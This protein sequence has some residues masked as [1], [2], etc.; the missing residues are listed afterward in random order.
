MGITGGVQWVR[1][2]NPNVRSRFIYDFLMFSGSAMWA[3]TMLS[4]YLLQ[5]TSSAKYVGFAEGTQGLCMA[6]I[7]IP[8]GVLADRLGRGQIL[9]AASFVGILATAAVSAALWCKGSEHAVYTMFVG[10]LGLCGL[11]NGLASPALD[12]NFADSIATGDR[13]VLYTAKQMCVYWASAAGPLV[14]VVLF[15]TL[16]NEWSQDSIRAVMQVEILKRERC[17]DLV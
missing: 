7:A 15:C 5:L 16:G 3:S 6:C 2:L 12:S 10:G 11:Y 8:S 13:S 1:E 14:N 4:V 17:S 9:R